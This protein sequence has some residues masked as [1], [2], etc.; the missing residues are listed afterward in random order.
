[1]YTSRL[2]VITCYIAAV[3]CLS[4]C[5]RSLPGGSTQNLNL[6]AGNGTA[7]SYFTSLTEGSGSRDLQIGAAVAQS[8]RLCN[9]YFS[10]ISATE[11]GFD[12]TLGVVG[13]L[14]HFG[15]LVAD[16]TGAK[17]LWNAYGVTAEGVKGNLRTGILRGNETTVL[18]A[19]IKK[20]RKSE[21]EK[22]Y[23]S[24]QTG[25][26][27][28]NASFELLLPVIEE[29]HSNCTLTNAIIE[30]QESVQPSS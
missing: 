4:G 28:E 11:R 9:E 25:G 14:T 7:G 29:Y 27:Y 18:M 8:N 17:T 5:W 16:T 19:A 20:Y 30:L 10:T 6:I 21:W 15:G 22:F 13:T 26:L 1:M 2:K 23:K 12:T 24:L 3:L